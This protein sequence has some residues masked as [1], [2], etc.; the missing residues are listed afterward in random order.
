MYVRN[1]LGSQ[2]RRIIVENL[3]VGLKFLTIKLNA[4]VN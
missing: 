2:Y 1:M 3:R 4:C